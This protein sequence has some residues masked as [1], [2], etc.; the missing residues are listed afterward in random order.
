MKGLE[1]N[2]YYVARR[3]IIYHEIDFECNDTLVKAAWQKCNVRPTDVASLRTRA[4]RNDRI[5]AEYR[6]RYGKC[7]I[8]GLNNGIQ[9]SQSAENSQNEPNIRKLKNAF[10]N[11]AAPSNLSRQISSFCQCEYYWGMLQGIRVS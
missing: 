10:G 7:L 9:T 11:G 5:G 1:K 4:H 8:I 6:L 2:A 3:Y